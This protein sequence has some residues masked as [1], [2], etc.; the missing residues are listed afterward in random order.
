M[1]LS[2]S[3]AI[4]DFKMWRFRIIDAS[5]G[6]LN[7]SVAFFFNNFLN[8]FVLRIFRSLLWNSSRKN[9][10][11]KCTSLAFMFIWLVKCFW[12][13][14]SGQRVH[15]LFFSLFFFLFTCAMWCFSKLNAP[16][17][18]LC[19]YCCC[20]CFFSFNSILSHKEYPVSIKYRSTRINMPISYARSE[21]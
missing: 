13:N 4:V 15:T 20:C 10:N 17:L 3:N 21:V 2:A 5:N 1:R 11:K 8:I 18:W 6:P 14:W 12:F 19:R 16:L 9:K 7:F